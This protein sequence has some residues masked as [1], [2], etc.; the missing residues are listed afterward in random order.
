MPS[1]QAKLLKPMLRF[2]VRHSFRS[3][4]KF[5]EERERIER[6]DRLALSMDRGFTRRD[7]IIGTIPVQW[8]TTPESDPDSVILYFHGGGFCLRTPVV[9]GQILAKLCAGSGTPD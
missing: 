9:H 2:G 8:I 4:E 7:E 6:R 1:L 5:P 3:V